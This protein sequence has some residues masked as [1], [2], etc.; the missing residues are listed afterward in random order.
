MR[1][2]FGLGTSHR[3]IDAFIAGLTDLLE[4]GPQLEYRQDEHT[5]DFVPVR[6]ARTWPTFEGLPS[7]DTAGHSAGCGQF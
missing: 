5:G 4:R 1:A 2:S 7:L 6:D 3:D